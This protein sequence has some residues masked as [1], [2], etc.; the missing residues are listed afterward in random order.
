MVAKLFPSQG[1]D[2]KGRT[3]L[4]WGDKMGVVY[5]HYREKGAKKVSKIFRT[6]LNLA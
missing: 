3:K 1:G 5:R 6:F 4:Y 2:T